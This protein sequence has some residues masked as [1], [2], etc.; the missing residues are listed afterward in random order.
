VKEFE[1]TITFET[2]DRWDGF[3]L[4]FRVMSAL[5]AFGFAVS[6]RDIKIVEDLPNETGKKGKTR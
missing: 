3:Y 5:R 2:P 6:Q 1:V 4:M